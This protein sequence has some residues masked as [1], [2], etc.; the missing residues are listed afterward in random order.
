MKNSRRRTNQP[1]TPKGVDIFLVPPSEL[2]E[3][4]QDITVRRTGGV[5]NL[6]G[7]KYQLL[8]A[9]YKMLSELT[10]GSEA[11]IQLEGL[12]DLDVHN[13]IV[14]GQ[15]E[16]IQL[17][18]SVNAMNAGSFWDLGILQ[19]FLE[20]YRGSPDATFR[21]VYNMPIASGNLQQLVQHKLSKEA[22]THWTVKL[23]GVYDSLD[24]ST[25]QRFLQQITFEY[26]TEAEAQEK[27]L[28]AL[29]S[30]F[31][32]HAASEEQFLKAVFYHAFEWSR[33]R[34]IISYKQLASVVQAVKDNY[35]KAPIN[36]AI[37]HNWLERV[38]YEEESDANT[39]G[40]F[41]GQ[42]ARP[43]HIAQK[44]PVRRL[45]WES[46]IE[47]ELDT[48]AVVAIR[49]S[50]GQGKSTLA[51]QVGYNL[52]KRGRSI[53]QL[54]LCNSQETINAVLDYLQAW[55]KVGELPVVIVDDLTNQVARWSDLVE[56]AA[57]L[58]I[59]F[60]VTSREED[61]Y[62]YGADPATV[63]VQTVVT[64]LSSQEAENIFQELKSRGKLNENVTLWQPAWEAVA[65]KGLLI[66]YVYLLTQGQMLGDRLEMQVKELNR[67]QRNAAAK[68]EI[69]R[70]VALADCLNLQIDTSRLLRHVQNTVRFD[71]DRGEVL[72]QLE[73][74]YFLRFGKQCVEGLHPVRSRHLVDLLHE[75]VPLVESMHSVF[76]LIAA[77]DTFAFF[78]AAP[79]MLGAEDKPEFY[80]QVASDLTGRSFQEMTN[81]LD[82]LLRGAA[83]KYWQDNRNVFD[84]VF[85]TGAIELFVYQTLP[86]TRLD[87]LE[88]ISGM[89]SESLNS[90]QYLLDWKHKLTPLSLVESDLVLLTTLLHGKLSIQSVFPHYQGIGSLSEW[91]HRMGLVLPNLVSWDEEYILQEL[92][93]KTL[94]EVEELFRFLWLSD[95]PRC[96]A[97]VKQYKN[98]LLSLLKVR[99]NT[100]TIYE[101]GDELY[102][103]YLLDSEQVDKANSFSV[104]RLET[105]STF[106]SDYSLYHTKAK[107][108]SFLPEHIHNNVLQNA[109]KRLSHNTLRSPNELR[110]NQIWSNTI[111]DIYRAGSIYEWQEYLY[112]LREA[113]VE[114]AKRSV[115]F[116]ET[117]LEQ[118]DS[119]NKSA[120]KAV[121]EQ[122]ELLEKLRQNQPKLNNG[123]DYEAQERLIN[124]WL[125]SL[126]NFVGQFGGVITPKT[127]NSR[128]LATINLT[129]TV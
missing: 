62:R 98:E 100:P 7:M 114:F 8:Y 4:I 26:I 36:E 60:L 10:P 31:D 110:I 38:V 15:A 95:A 106:L 41:D 14:V 63:P 112:R 55:V 72:K 52:Q 74:E 21:L 101:E 46:R 92:R 76:G 108:F 99:T 104:S 40:Y 50:S 61:W 75:T 23:K 5:I 121:V 69:L 80:A 19:N 86:F 42:S 94:A 107:M 117:R 32:I 96:Q 59:K 56:R 84:S 79:E 22:L 20:V 105:V 9:C 97:F 17:K 1:I 6:R 81:A 64:T 118:S 103:E 58:P 45:G 34:A 83:L 68:L 111:L 39:D 127:D 129:A 43:R 44:L 71:S 65:D 82:G 116:L 47:A 73:R 122:S 33:E 91:I 67:E 109:E 78:L 28:R 27:C 124:D 37:R 11:I 29:L 3:Y 25:I 126:R 128:N 120:S 30:N 115:R 90:V 66:E 53:Y 12:E 113:A 49:A 48:A 16:Y 85:E 119:R 24:I 88:Q 77:E 125:F 13:T 35:S 89:E 2:D 123:N 57:E 18:T 93:M 70:L 87:T 54:R 51:W 102:L